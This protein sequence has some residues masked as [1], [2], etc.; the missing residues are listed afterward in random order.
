MLHLGRGQLQR[1]GGKG[2]RNQQRLAGQ[3]G[4]G[5]VPLALQAFIDDAL[6]RGVHVHQHQPVAVLREDVHPVQ[7]GQRVA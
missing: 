4:G 1:G 3:G 2:G 6:V 5:G 7:L